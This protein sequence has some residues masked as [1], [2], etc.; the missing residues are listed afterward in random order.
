MKAA[1]LSDGLILLPQCLNQTDDDASGKSLPAN[2][3][4][5]RH[6]GSTPRSGRSPG[7]GDD[8]HPFQYSCLDNA[9]DRG[10]QWVIVQRV[11]ESDMTE[12]T[13]HTHA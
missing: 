10:A 13:Q 11:A 8:R 7:G 12:A 6:S 1:K 3:E 2:T 5:V 4:D 9:M